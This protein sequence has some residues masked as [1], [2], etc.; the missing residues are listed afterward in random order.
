MSPPFNGTSQ[1]QVASAALLVS[2]AAP[3]IPLFGAGPVHIDHKPHA[4]PDPTVAAAA[5]YPVTAATA[6]AIAATLGRSPP[7]WSQPAQPITAAKSP[8]SKSP[9][10]VGSGKINSVKAGGVH[11]SKGST[12]SVSSSSTVGASGGGHRRRASASASIDS[13]ERDDDAADKND[14]ND[15]NN[16]ASAGDANEKQKRRRFLE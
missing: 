3:A 2:S 7:Q 8:S 6:A 1:Q 12:S 10:A 5:N 15:N 9:S 14:N 16:D 11:K 4:A 13:S